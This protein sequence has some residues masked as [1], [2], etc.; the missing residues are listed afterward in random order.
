MGRKAEQRGY[1]IE[2]GRGGKNMSNFQYITG[3][4]KM[5]L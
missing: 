5:F 1:R 4:D 2:D 3:G